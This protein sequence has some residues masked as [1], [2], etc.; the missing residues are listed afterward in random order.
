MI[1]RR[2]TIDDIAAAGHCAKGA[3]SWFRT[4][5]LD[6]A[7]F[8]K[9]GIPASDLLATGDALAEQVVSRAQSRHDG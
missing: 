5:N 9:D 4:M 2:I 3:R 6:F 1:E 8:R 7:A